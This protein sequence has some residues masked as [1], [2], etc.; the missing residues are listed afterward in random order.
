MERPV[1][2]DFPRERAF[3][4]WI[5]ALLTHVARRLSRLDFDVFFLGTAIGVYIFRHSLSI[6]TESIC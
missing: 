1:R 3:L 4:A 6:I 5:A 2:T